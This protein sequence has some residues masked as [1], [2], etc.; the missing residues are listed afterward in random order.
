MSYT[1]DKYRAANAFQ[2]GAINGY[3]E[4]CRN[5]VYNSHKSI[6]SP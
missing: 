5:I 4:F 3:K 2:Y 6:T 1:C